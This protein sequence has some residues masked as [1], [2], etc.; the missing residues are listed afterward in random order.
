MKERREVS[1]SPS[2]WAADLKVHFF[3]RLQTK[4]AAISL[5]RHA[6]REERV[7][8]LLLYME[9]LKATFTTPKHGIYGS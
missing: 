7:A 8:R 2:A 1:V 4:A 3:T 5:P 6:P 9:T